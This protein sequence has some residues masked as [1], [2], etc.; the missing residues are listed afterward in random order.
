MTGAMDHDV[1]RVTV[2]RVGKR[3]FGDAAGS[4]GLDMGFVL[5]IGMMLYSVG[6]CVLF[7]R[8]GHRSPDVRHFE[9]ER[10]HPAIAVVIPDRVPSEWVD[11]YGAEQGG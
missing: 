5:I 1:R 6:M 10:S 11:A 2:D 4:G 9:R 8:V 7:Q 3:P